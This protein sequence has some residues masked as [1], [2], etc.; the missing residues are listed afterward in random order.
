MGSVDAPGTS[1]FHN[2]YNPNASSWYKVRA[3]DMSGGTSAISLAVPVE[4]ITPPMVIFEPTTPTKN[5]SLEIIIGVGNEVEIANNED[6]LNSELHA[7]EGDSVYIWDLGDATENSVIKYLFVRAFTDEIPGQ[8]FVD[9]IQVSFTPEITLENNMAIASVSQTLDISNSSI[10][11]MRFAESREL[12]SGLSYEDV[13]TLYQYTFN[14][15]LPDTQTVYGEF[16][17]DFGFSY[18]DSVNVLPDELLSPSFIVE[19]GSEATSNTVLSIISELGATEMRFS[20]DLENFGA[21][22]P[23]TAET[24]YTLVA[25]VSGEKIIYAQFKNDWVEFSDIVANTITWVDPN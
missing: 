24:E 9:S 1:F 7:I 11:G 17:C 4:I 23:Y 18:I 16:T 14:S 25:P 15:S 5:I 8:T 20:E 21:W 6:F 19:G 10:L 13:D 2:D 12:L 22:E 3:V